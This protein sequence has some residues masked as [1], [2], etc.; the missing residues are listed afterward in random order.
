MSIPSLVVNLMIVSLGGLELAVSRRIH[1]TLKCDKQKVGHN[2]PHPPNI[3]CQHFQDLISP[4]ELQQNPFQWDVTR[5]NYPGVRAAAMISTYHMH[6]YIP[7]EYRRQRT[8]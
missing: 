5:C 8:Y 1:S 7:R 6:R 2:D 4:E 3:H